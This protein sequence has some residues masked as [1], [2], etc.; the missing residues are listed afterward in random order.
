M[1]FGAL[2]INPRA[3]STKIAVF[4]GGEPENAPRSAGA[5]L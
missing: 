3:T 1:P 4:H 2:V 5:G